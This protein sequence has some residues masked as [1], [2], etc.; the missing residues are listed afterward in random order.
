MTWCDPCA[1]DPL[2]PEELRQLG[3]FWLD[4]QPPAPPG[5]PRRGNAQNV[6]VTR[7]HV[8]YDSAH[9][10]DDLQFQTTGDRSNFQGR[11]VMRH[12]FKGE[13]KC[14]AGEQYQ[15]QLPGRRE[16]EAQTLASLTG[17]D[18]DDI[19]AEMEIPV[20]PLP[21]PDTKPTSWWKDLWGN[22]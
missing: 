1:A 19:R 21:D 6:F 22:D 20:Q 12:P 10:P 9:F 5:F 11:Y 3:V 8:R 17:W 14:E 18:V 4:E 16:V 13:M 2:S 7:L 15:S